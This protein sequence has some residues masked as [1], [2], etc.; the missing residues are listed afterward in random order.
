MN[1]PSVGRIMLL[2]YL[3][4]SSRYCS[5]LFSS[6][7]KLELE[8]NRIAQHLILLIMIITLLLMFGNPVGLEIGKNEM[9]NSILIGIGIYIWFILTTK[10]S[11]EYNI[12]VLLVLGL[13]FLFESKKIT[14]YKNVINDDTLNND[15]KK[16][17]IDSMNKYQK[18]LLFGLGGITLIGFFTKLNE[19]KNIQIGGGK[20]FSYYKYLLY[21]N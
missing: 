8:N 20:N 2:V 1:I 7:L 9:I 18:W 3:I 15:K 14:D 19:T 11:L 21:D 5:D 17:L 6:S 16:N 4:L 10:L 13:Y 12:I